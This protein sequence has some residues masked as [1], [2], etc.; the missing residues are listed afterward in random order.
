MF[1]NDCSKICMKIASYN[2][3]YSTKSWNDN[4]LLL[5]RFECSAA[6]IL[7][8]EEPE[9]LEHSIPEGNM[10]EPGIPT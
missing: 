4:E 3:K 2:S 1:T 10:G 9:I 8:Q 7:N 6:S 5:F